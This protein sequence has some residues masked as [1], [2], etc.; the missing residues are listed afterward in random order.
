MLE[1][2]VCLLF[3]PVRRRVLLIIGRPQPSTV[4]LQTVHL[5]LE[6][7]NSSLFHDTSTLRCTY[8]RQHNI[9]LLSIYAQKIEEFLPFFTYE[10]DIFFFIVNIIW[11]KHSVNY[12]LFVFISNRVFNF[13]FIFKHIRY[14][15]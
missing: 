12:Q 2:N 14:W 9:N 8:T 5:T 6:K 15:F 7:K 3:F 1:H 4:S 11:C 10:I 13:L